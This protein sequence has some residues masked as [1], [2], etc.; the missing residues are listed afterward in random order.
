MTTEW[1]PIETAPKDA[2]MLLLLKRGHPEDYHSRVVVSFWGDRLSGL[3][4]TEEN[5]WLNWHEGFDG[6][7][8][9]AVVSDP[10]HWMPLPEPPHDH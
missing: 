2:A 5:C 7:S 6:D 4:D 3:F 9:W 10:T 1:Q 8:V